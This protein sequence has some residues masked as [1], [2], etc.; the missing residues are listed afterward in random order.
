VCK[1]IALKH[2]K[3]AVPP[4]SARGKKK[5]LR[6][7]YYLS[8]FIRDFQNCEEVRSLFNHVAG[9]EVIPHCCFSNVPQV[10][11]SFNT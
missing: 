5:G 6:G 11:M 3:S 9:E 1:Q 7:L 4:A 10:L 8:P 2:E